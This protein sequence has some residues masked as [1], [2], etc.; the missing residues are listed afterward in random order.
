MAQRVM[1]ASR[2]AYLRAL[3]ATLVAIAAAAGSVAVAPAASAVDAPLAPT[4]VRGLFTTGDGESVAIAWDAPD[5]TLSGPIL[6]YR[7]QASRNG[8]S[9]WEQVGGPNDC[10]VGQI[11]C[12]ARTDYRI[13]YTLDR[14][15]TYTFQVAARGEAGWGP[16]SASSAPLTVNPGGR[17]QPGAPRGLVVTPS[18]TSLVVR[19]QAPAPD[20]FAPPTSYDVDWRAVDGRWLGPETTR[21]RRFTIPNLRRGESYVVRVRSVRNSDSGEV[22]AWTQAPRVRVL[23]VQRI[24]GDFAPPRSLAAP[25]RTRLAP[26]DLRTNAGQRV[27]VSVAWQPAGLRASAAVRLTGSV[28]PI[29]VRRASCGRVVVVLNGSPGVVAVKWEARATAKFDAM[30]I[31]SVYRIH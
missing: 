20:A 14:Y 17:T 16:W 28:D 27:R 25:G 29:V 3:S 9:T 26:C 24:A 5:T 10:E 18:G 23:Q 7:I 22:S 4:N 19:W 12:E 6:A 15:V 8:G 1:K 30:K 31:R 2:G 11:G 21:E 13:F